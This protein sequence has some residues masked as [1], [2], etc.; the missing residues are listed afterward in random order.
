MSRMMMM[1]SGLEAGRNA[2]RGAG[3][4]GAVAF[5]MTFVILLAGGCSSGP[6][7]APDR[8]I[9]V[10]SGPRST[11]AP[12]EADRLDSPKNR[13]SSEAT[14]GE[15]MQREAV[16]NAEPAL[17]S[18]PQT[19]AEPVSASDDPVPPAV[20]EPFPGIVV[21][22]DPA[23][24]R[25]VVELTGTVCLN[26]GWLEQIACE[27]GTREHEALVVPR[28]EASQ[29]H[30]ALLLAGHVSGRPGYWRL[31]DDQEYQFEPPLGSELDVWVRYEDAAGETVEEPIRRWIRDSNGEHDFP[32]IPWIFGGSRFA[33]NPDWMSQEGEH[34][35][36]DVTG[37]IIGL[38]T[39]G[40][41]TIGW[42]EVIADA[43]AVHPPVWEANPDAMPPVGTDVVLVLRPWESEG[44]NH[45]GTQ[46]TD[47]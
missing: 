21:H 40:D 6:E 24:G 43:A 17:D 44:S 35:V 9:Q 34:Y 27:P 36:A 38:V 3:A 32:L 37:S 20:I 30:A 23:G 1:R 42:R 7:P 12:R 11:A 47:E 16:V 5:A 26:E 28:A 33:P 15:D 2:D 10:D 14:F 22:P 39:F 25:G 46:P 8:S 18:I 29:V 19:P 4:R 45:G 31:D 41:E 13:Q